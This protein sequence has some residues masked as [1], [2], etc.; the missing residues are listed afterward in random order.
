VD[1]KNRLTLRALAL[2][3]KT[4]KIIFSFFIKIEKRGV[5]IVKDSQPAKHPGLGSYHEFVLN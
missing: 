2:T 3:S 5:K 1:K 4:S